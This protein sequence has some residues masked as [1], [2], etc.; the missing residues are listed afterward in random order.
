MRS[1]KQIHA[2]L[3]ETRQ[4]ITQLETRFG[5]LQQE[6]HAAQR[7]QHEAN[8]RAE[9]I[10]LVNSMPKAQLEALLKGVL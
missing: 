4:A 7:A 1:T 5:E 2:D 3:Y 9:V 8:Q 10:R 6:L